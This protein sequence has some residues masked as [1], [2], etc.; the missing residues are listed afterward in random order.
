MG[1]GAGADVA[2]AVAAMNK[3]IGMPSGLAAMGVTADHVPGIIDYAQKDLAARSN[4]RR[5][6]AN[7]YEAMVAETM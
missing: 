1:L 6:S 2:D 4:P 3:R 5:A 7:D